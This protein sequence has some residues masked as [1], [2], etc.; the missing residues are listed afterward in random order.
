M[1]KTMYLPRPATSAIAALL[2]LTA[3]AALA[4]TAPAP[5]APVPATPVPVQSTTQPAPMPV[6]IPPVA[7]TP[8]A[9]APATTPAAPVTRDPLDLEQPTK[10]DATAEAADRKRVGRGTSVLG[11]VVTGGLLSS[12]KQ[13]QT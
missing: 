1:T 5:D 4:Q 11:R 12:N 3:P 10:A 2:V 7:P 8:T 13:K 9:P 6:M